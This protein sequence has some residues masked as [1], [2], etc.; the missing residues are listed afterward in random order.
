MRKLM[1]HGFTTFVI[2]HI[3]GFPICQ[4]WEKHHNSWTYQFTVTALH[5]SWN[6]ITENVE[7]NHYKSKLRT[8]ES[9]TENKLRLKSESWEL[10][11]IKWIMI[12]QV[13]YR[14]SMTQ[15]NHLPT[16]LLPCRSFLIKSLFIKV[17]VKS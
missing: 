14:W 4:E 6:M 12:K 15:W 11:N 2:H 8:L 3:C 16:L 7:K 10:C 1:S 5:Q 13:Y 9:R 17:H